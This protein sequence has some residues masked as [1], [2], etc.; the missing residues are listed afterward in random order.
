MIGPGGSLHN[1]RARFEAQFAPAGRDWVW[2]RGGHGP[3]LPVSAEDRDM[4]VADFAR[5]TR[6]LAWG[7]VPLAIVVF[8]AASL[9]RVPDW[10]AA[11]PFALVWGGPLLWAWHAPRRLLE[12]RAPVAPALSGSDTRRMNLRS[13]PWSVLV[14]GGLV[15][16][17][18]VA[19]VGLGDQPWAPANRQYYAWAALFL[20]VFAG[21][22]VAK[23]RAG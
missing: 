2:R 4:L 3:A 10:A 6:W 8:A 16:V 19:R 9:W 5:T 12:G 23:R 11:L 1:L 17:G 13:L 18:L 15:S 20:A 22:A 14:M 7:W 21:L